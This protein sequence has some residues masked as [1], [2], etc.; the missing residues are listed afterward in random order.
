MSRQAEWIWKAEAC[1]QGGDTAG[2][3]YYLNLALEAEKMDRIDEV[4]A[5]WEAAPVQIVTGRQSYGY[6]MYPRG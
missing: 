6:T 5:R 4:F 3:E 2:V 1:E